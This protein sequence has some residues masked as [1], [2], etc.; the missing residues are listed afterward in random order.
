MSVCCTQYALLCCSLPRDARHD[1]HKHE[2]HECVGATL[3]HEQR[4]ITVIVRVSVAGPDVR[5][6]LVCET[7]EAKKGIARNKDG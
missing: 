4:L 6:L 7:Q 3:F 5:T 2:E 1:E